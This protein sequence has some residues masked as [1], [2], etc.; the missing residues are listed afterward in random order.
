MYPIFLTVTMYRAGIFLVHFC[1][2]TTSPDHNLPHPVPALWT[3]PC[4]TTNPERQRI[5]AAEEMGSRL[6]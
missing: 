1:F 2:S 3:Q 5:G 6:R 4:S